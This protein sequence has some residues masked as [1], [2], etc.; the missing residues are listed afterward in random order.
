MDN[1][2]SSA[3]EIAADA[4]SRLEQWRQGGGSRGSA[5]ADSQAVSLSPADIAGMIDHTL[6][7]PDATEE[8]I[9]RLCAEAARYGFASVCVNS[10]WVPLCDEL[11]AGTG[12]AVCTVVGF[13][14]G[15]NLPAVK[16][17]EAEQAIEAGASEVDMV[18]A[19]G[20]LKGGDYA[21]VRDDIATV[22]AASHARSAKV[23]TII[24]TC[25]L[26]DEG[27]AVAC[28]LAQAAGADFVKTSTGF[29]GPGANAQDIALMRAIVGPILGVKAA[30]GVRTLDD[31]LMMASVGATRIGASAGVQIMQ[32]LEGRSDP[33]GKKVTASDKPEG[34][35]Y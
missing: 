27:K 15:A 16:R 21:Y 24:E 20:W 30:G 4:I 29:S 33:G 17:Y 11:L 6:L 8:Q 34:A 19:V 23:K 13:P 22:V 7:K 10:G 5:L 12:V 1:R 9:R 3:D 26:T 14:L 18:I 35:L 2:H 31:L 28:A 25:L 32:G